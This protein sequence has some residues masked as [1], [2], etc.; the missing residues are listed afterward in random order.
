MIMVMISMKVS[1][2]R[3]QIKIMKFIGASNGYIS[4]PY[5]MEAAVSSSLANLLAFA[6]YYALVLYLTPWFKD[7]L[8]G[9]ISFPIA[10][11]FFA[12]QFAAGVVLAIILGNLASFAA[13][14][15]MLKK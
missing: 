9:V 6:F 10:W 15:R 5:L 3:G 14:R 8:T 1:S 2:K 4:S 7:F 11:Q 13:V 12:Y